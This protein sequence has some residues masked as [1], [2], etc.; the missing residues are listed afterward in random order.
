MSTPH[1]QA[2]AQV[3]RAFFSNEGFDHFKQFIVL[4]SGFKG[5]TDQFQ[6][7]AA[8]DLGSIPEARIPAVAGHGT[9]LV[10]GQ[11]HGQP[12]L[13]QTGRI[14]LY[15]GYTPEH[16]VFT[17]RVAASLGVE[18]LILTNAAGGLSSDLNVGDVVLLQDHLNLTGQNPLCGSS[19][20]PH[21]LFVDMSGAY[22]PAGRDACKSRLGLKEAIYAGVLGPSYETPAE[23]RYYRTT[24]A[25]CIGMSTVL[26]TIAARQLG[27]Q[28]C[29]VSLITNVAGGGSGGLDHADVLEQGRSRQVFL[30]ETL[31]TI[32]KLGAGLGK[33]FS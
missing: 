10:A 19:K 2:A 13:V 32:A 21:E 9:S 24:G 31:S 15:E 28:V 33:E 20:N 18:Q 17:I 6:A 25:D 22:S 23:A 26:E 7:L 12:I 14:H 4:G 8:M 29:G 1:V 11:L 3:V 5:F 27:L 30:S 16:I